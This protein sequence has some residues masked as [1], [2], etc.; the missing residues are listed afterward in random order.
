MNEETEEERTQRFINEFVENATKKIESKIEAA[1]AFYTGQEFI[2]YCRGIND[3][4]D[5]IQKETAVMA[6]IQQFTN[7]LNKL[8]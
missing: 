3:I 6:T 8:A 5:I 7:D 4:M 2:S 1:Q